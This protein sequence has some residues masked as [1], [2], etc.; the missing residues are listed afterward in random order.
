MIY[1]VFL[2]NLGLTI[3]TEGIVIALLFRRW[4][5]IYYSVLCNILTNPALNLILLIVVKFA[6]VAYYT[7]TLIVLEITVLFIEAGVLKHLCGLRY[8]KAITVSCLMNFTSFVVGVF[9]Y[10]I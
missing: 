4:D 3:L 5:Y 9:L 10:N 6:G 7:P 2:I 1:L 8:Y